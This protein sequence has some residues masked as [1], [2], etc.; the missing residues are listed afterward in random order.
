VAAAEVFHKI[1]R[2][3]EKTGT[4]AAKRGNGFPAVENFFEKIRKKVLTKRKP[5]DILVKRS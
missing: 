2:I 1:L 5:C 4:E 3:V